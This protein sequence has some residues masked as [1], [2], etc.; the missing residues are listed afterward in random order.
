MLEKNES[1]RNRTRKG[2]FFCVWIILK[3]QMYNKEIA[4]NNYCVNVFVYDLF[5]KTLVTVRFAF[6][7][8]C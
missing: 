8:G 7:K 3:R 2:T 4:A 6:C 1:K 5:V